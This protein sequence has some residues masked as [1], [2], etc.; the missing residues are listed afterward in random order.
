MI[1]TEFQRF[2][3]E[4]SKS[5]TELKELNMTAEELARDAAR[6]MEY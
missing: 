1:F 2:S 4:M 6:N 5:Y 3:G